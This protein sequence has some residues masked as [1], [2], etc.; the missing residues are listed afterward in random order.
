MDLGVKLCLCIEG[1]VPLE[2]VVLSARLN[3]NTA[4][5]NGRT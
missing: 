3:A 1:I 5:C 2:V 4:G